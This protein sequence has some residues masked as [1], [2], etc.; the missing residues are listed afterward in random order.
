MNSMDDSGP[1]SK[2]AFMDIK[3]SDMKITSEQSGG[4]PFNSHTAHTFTDIQVQEKL[5]KHLGMY[6]TNCRP[7]PSEPVST[8]LPTWSES[9]TRANASREK[10]GGGDPKHFAHVTQ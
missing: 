6:A 2:P 10:R 9:T 4:S 7:Q 1:A 8:F 3:W 5:K